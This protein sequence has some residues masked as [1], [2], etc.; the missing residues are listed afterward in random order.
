MSTPGGTVPVPHPEP[1]EP[2]KPVN[3]E[4]AHQQPKDPEKHHKPEPD[5]GHSEHPKQ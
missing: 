1:T 2:A 4:P 3:P 5:S